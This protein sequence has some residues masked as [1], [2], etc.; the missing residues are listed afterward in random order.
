[1]WFSTNSSTKKMIRNTISMNATRARMNEAIPTSSVIP[2]PMPSTS[3]SVVHTDI[4]AVTASVHIV[5]SP[6]QPAIRSSV[7]GISR[8]VSWNDPSRRTPPS[9]PRP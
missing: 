6:N 9:P 3:E 4:S 1:M 2:A 7:I 8:M 5:I